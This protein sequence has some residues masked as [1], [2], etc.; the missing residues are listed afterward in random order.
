MTDRKC[1]GMRMRLRPSLALLAVLL[2]LWS[3][4]G[5][6]AQALGDPASP[7]ISDAPDTAAAATTAV[8]QLARLQS[9]L[10]A[11]R[12]QEQAATGVAAQDDKLKM[13]V[14]LLQK[15]IE[16]QQ[17]L[18]VLLMEQMKKLGTA[19]PAVEKLQT[20]VATLEARSKQAAQRDRE[21]AQA[22]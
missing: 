12:S 1:W 2:S 4:T 14:D 18:I 22:I 19:G 15:Q 5:A 9:S 10:E 13:Q 11:L 20:D 21:L 8:A 6:H 3:A 7:K 17:K 16:V